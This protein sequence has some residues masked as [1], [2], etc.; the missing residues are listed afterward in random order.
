MDDK[1]KKEIAKEIV[2]ELFRQINETVGR[3]VIKKILWGALGLAVFA[4]ISTGYIKL[5]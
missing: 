3:S 5:G 4:G 1:D 2:A